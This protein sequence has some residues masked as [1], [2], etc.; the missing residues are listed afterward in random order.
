M[1]GTEKIDPLVIGKFA[2]PRCFKNVQTFPVTYK[3]NSKA[4]MTSL[5]WEEFLREKDKKFIQ[6]KHRVLFIIDN[7]P[8]HPE[9]KL[10]AI[11]LVYLPPNSTSTSQPMDQG[12]MKSRL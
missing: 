10:K 7:C 8:A 9:I 12:V 6:Q 4:W 1:S 3:S 2:K 11:K 5:I